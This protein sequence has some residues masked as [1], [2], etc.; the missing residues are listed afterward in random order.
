V[1]PSPTYSA[2]YSLLPDPSGM[3]TA[4]GIP[5]AHLPEPYRT[6]LAHTHH[7]TVT[8]ERFFGDAVDVVVLETWQSGDDYVRKILLKLRSTGRVVQFGIV[9]IDLSKLAAEV[10][11]RIVEGKTPL[12]RVLIEH[13]VL[14]TVSP[15]GF[16]QVEPHAEFCGWFDLRACEPLFG[17]LGIITA[18]GRPAI[19]VLEVLAPVRSSDGC[20]A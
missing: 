2:L 6:L 14:R 3:P 9:R 18:D 19:E 20:L 5:A 17:R 13:D 11:A 7:M 8:V 15:T 4:H 10:S 1:H 12:G 16:V